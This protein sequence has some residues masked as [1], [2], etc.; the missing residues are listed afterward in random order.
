MNNKDRI[1][2]VTE[3]K[4]KNYEDFCNKVIESFE[5]LWEHKKIRLSL[6]YDELSEE[7]N[8]SKNTIKKIV[9][10]RLREYKEEIKKNEAA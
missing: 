3:T 8:R 9:G 5:Y 10:K 7:Y 1:K 4:K 6:I 2:K